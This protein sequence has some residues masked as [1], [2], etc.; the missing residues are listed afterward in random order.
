MSVC[1]PAAKASCDADVNNLAFCTDDPNDAN[2]DICVCQYS[3]LGISWN[4]TQCTTG[5]LYCNVI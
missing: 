1:E 4:G 2:Q 3:D 5:K